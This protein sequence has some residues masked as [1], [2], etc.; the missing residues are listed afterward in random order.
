MTDTTSIKRLAPPGRESRPTNGVPGGLED[1]SPEWNSTSSARRPPTG[2][3]WPRQQGAAAGEDQEGAN[4]WCRLRAIGPRGLLDS[5][6]GRSY[7]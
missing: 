3:R 2:R 5:L 6:S 7:D 4:Y 1:S